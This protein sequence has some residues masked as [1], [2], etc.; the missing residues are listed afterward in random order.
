METVNPIPEIAEIPNTWR[1]FEP[2]GN[3]ETLK[4]TAAKVKN[5][6]PTIFGYIFRFGGQNGD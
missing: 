4:R 2:F 1:K 6:S 3:L 5:D